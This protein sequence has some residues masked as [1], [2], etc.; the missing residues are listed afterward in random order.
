[1]N[2]LSMNLLLQIFAIVLISAIFGWLLRK[3]VPS[4]ADMT[5]IYQKDTITLSADASGIPMLKTSSLNGLAYGMGFLWSRDRFIQMHLWRSMGEGDISHA[6]RNDG[7][8]KLDLLVKTLLPDSLINMIYSE[9]PPPV[10]DYINAMTLGFNDGVKL[11]SSSGEI[12]FMFYDLNMKNHD[13]KPKDFFKIF[14]LRSLTG[15]L[16]QAMYEREILLSLPISDNSKELVIKYLQNKYDLLPLFARS[17]FLP[18]Y[19]VEDERINC[20]VMESNILPPL[21]YPVIWKREDMEI[22]LIFAAGEFLPYYVIA[23]NS[24][25]I[26]NN[27]DWIYISLAILNRD[28]V[29]FIEKEKV[30]IVQAAGNDYWSI[31]QKYNGYTELTSSK[32]Y[33]LAGKVE[34]VSPERIENFLSEIANGKKQTRKFIGGI[35]SYRAEVERKVYNIPEDRVRLQNIF[36]VQMDAGN[37]GNL[38]LDNLDLW[39]SCLPHE[40]SLHNE[41][42]K[43]ILNLMLFESGFD[44]KFSVTP[45]VWHQFLKFTGEPLAEYNKYDSVI[46]FLKLIRAGLP[47]DIKPQI[48]ERFVKELYKKYPVS[49][50]WQ[51]DRVCKFEYKYL[52][53]NK[54]VNKVMSMHRMKKQYVYGLGFNSLYMTV[55]DELLVNTASLSGNGRINY[56]A[57]INEQLNNTRF[58]KFNAN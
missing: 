38:F 17:I 6:L 40:E 37:N 52:F 43:A 8:N 51:W 31:L 9:L 35:K 48:F 20:S 27:N 16:S 55:E 26:I 36:K 49:S 14:L 54:I 10:R 18:L 50:D 34:L 21:S 3:D 29:R 44:D 13:W 15:G 12:P 7:Y 30:K 45:F 58:W 56:Y 42:V 39:R 25:A 57:P 33:I 1:M 47:S 22:K 5:V 46:K 2:K 53:G 23:D 24:Q 28:A 4:T 11:R 41:Q 19:F 32:T